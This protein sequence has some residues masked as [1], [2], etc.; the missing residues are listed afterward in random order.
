[1]R[2]LSLIPPLLFNRPMNI[3]EEQKVK[4][5]E[6]KE[7]ERHNVLMNKAQGNMLYLLRYTVD[8]AAK[9][10]MRSLKYAEVHI[11]TYIYVFNYVPYLC[12]L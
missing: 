5:L 1:M 11:T 2:V 12:Y 9:K 3:I 8:E 10:K 4:V 7:R 6:H